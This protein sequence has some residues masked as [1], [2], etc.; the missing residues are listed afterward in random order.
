M[1]SDHISETITKV[2]WSEKYLWN[3][4]VLQILVHLFNLVQL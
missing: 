3:I 1:T 2:M 4:S